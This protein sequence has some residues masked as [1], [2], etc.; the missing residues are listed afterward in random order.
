[1]H[2]HYLEPKHIE[3][4]VKGSSIDLHLAQLNFKSLQGAIAYEY[5]LISELLPRTNVGMIK[6]AWLQR[7]SHITAGG[8]WCAGL[9]PLNNWQSMEWGCFKPNQPRIKDDGK[10]IKYEHPPSTATR[11]FYLR[12]TLQVWRETAQRYNLSL[13]DNISID[14]TG[15]AIGFWQWVM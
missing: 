10:P 1:M 9:D 4:L 5:L 2:L 13:P 8:W 14:S 15:E 11:V 3:E 12:V 6:S 7:Y